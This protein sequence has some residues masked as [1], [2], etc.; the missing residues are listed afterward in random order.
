MTSPEIAPT[1]PTAITALNNQAFIRKSGNIK[2]TSGVIFTE[3][4]AGAAGAGIIN[5]SSQDKIMPLVLF[6][7][8]AGLGAAIN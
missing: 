8:A 5:K 4:G 2:M 7:W 6:F 3:P 1:P